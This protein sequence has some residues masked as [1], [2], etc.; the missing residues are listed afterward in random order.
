[1][2]GTTSIF[3]YLYSDKEVDNYLREVQSLTDSEIRALRISGQI[4]TEQA[5][6]LIITRRLL[7]SDDPDAIQLLSDWLNVL[8]EDAAFAILNISLSLP[9]SFYIKKTSVMMSYTYSI[10][11]R[12]PGEDLGVNPSGFFSISLSRRIRL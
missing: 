11:Q 6:T 12:L 4:T 5:R 8:E 2:A 3:S 10:P 7:S 1:M 9:V